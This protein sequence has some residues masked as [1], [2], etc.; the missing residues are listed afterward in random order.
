MQYQKAPKSLLIRYINANILTLTVPQNI[1]WNAVKTVQWLGPRSLWW[2][3]PHISHIAIAW[4]KYVLRHPPV[5]Q[6]LLPSPLWKLGFGAQA[7]LWVSW[8][9]SSR[10]HAAPTRVQKP[11]GRLALMD[12][13]PRKSQVPMGPSMKKVR[14]NTIFSAFDPPPPLLTSAVENKHRPTEQLKCLLLISVLCATMNLINYNYLTVIS[15]VCLGAKKVLSRLAVLMHRLGLNV[16]LR[17]DITVGQFLNLIHSSF[18][19]MCVRRFSR[20]VRSQDRVSVSRPKFGI[21]CLGLGGQVS[22]SVS[23][24]WS[25][26]TRPFETFPQ[27]ATIYNDC[28]PHFESFLS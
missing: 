23:S 4:V 10:A 19:Y 8:L 18:V 6:A 12:Q 11:I 28:F 9:Q 21:S 3:S 27:F 16:K 24:L 1:L 2:S 25:R 13:G 5:R 7:S 26:V 20:D 15:D 22:V 14:K 17:F